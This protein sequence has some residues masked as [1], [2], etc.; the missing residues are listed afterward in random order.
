MPV[1]DPAALLRRLVDSSAR[2]RSAASKE[3]ALE[4][5]AEEARVV[6][7]ARH[8][9]AGETH[10]SLVTNVHAASAEGV[11]PV[12]PPALASLVTATRPVVRGAGIIAAP[13]LSASGAP[14]GLLAIS[15]DATT[16]EPLLELVI[17]EL[18]VVAGLALESAG[19]R[20]R[21]AATARSRESL[22]A[23]ISHDLRNPLNT[24][25]MSAGLLRDDLERN[26]VDPARATG[27]VQRMDRATHRMQALIEDLLEAS[28]I[29]ARRIDLAIREERAAQIVKDAASTGGAPATEKGA[30]VNCDSIDEEA[31]V[32]ADRGRT[33]QLLAKTIAYAARATGD[34]GLIRLSVSRQGDTVVFTTRAAGPGS[35]SLA[36]HD[37][38]RGGLA[39]L[40]ATGLAEIQRGTLRI[41]GTD[42]LAI[43]VTLPAAPT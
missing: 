5:I 25:A 2:V 13:L 17:A 39:L 3:E 36:S 16:P 34:G 15:A 43:K 9:W 42:G 1:A 38:G 29:D 33:V 28:R 6:A 31:R 26:E 22:L 30:A 21:A 40:I 23:A 14:E 32:L 4:T 18:A 35:V 27:L 24:F 7:G 10:G 11:P 37:E 41:E 8:A 19:L 20:E 12:D